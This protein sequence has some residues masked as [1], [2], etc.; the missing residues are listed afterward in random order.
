VELAR[1]LGR[2]QDWQGA[3]EV[4]RG[5]FRLHPENAELRLALIR[6]LLEAGEPGEAASVASGHGQ[7]LP[8]DIAA[9][10]PK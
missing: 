5:A 3:A 7:P 6:A 10:L 2:C 1:A 8:E 4:L 9:R